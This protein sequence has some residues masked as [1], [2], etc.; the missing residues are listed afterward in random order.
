MVRTAVTKSP[1]SP[2][3]GAAL[4]TAGKNETSM[5]EDMLTLGIG[6]GAADPEGLLSIF[7]TD[8]I[9]ELQLDSKVCSAKVDTGHGI[10]IRVCNHTGA[11]PTGS[12]YL[13]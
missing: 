5:P 10:P 3:L 1:K 13:W 8:D 11:K 6:N 4:K 7:A 9:P 2:A 12:P